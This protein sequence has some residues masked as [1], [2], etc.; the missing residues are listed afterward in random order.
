[1]KKSIFKHIILFVFFFLGSSNTMLAQYC[2]CPTC[3][4]NAC[5]PTS[6]IGCLFACFSCQG[7]QGA[8]TF[9]ESTTENCVGT[10]CET[11]LPV[12]LI[13]FSGKVNRQKTGVVLNWS[14]AS[15]LNN[16]GFEILRIDK[17]LVEWESLGFVEGKGTTNLENRYEFTDEKAN[18]GRNYYRLKQIDF[19]GV[20]EFSKMLSVDFQKPGDMVSIFPTLVKS[21]LFF[22]FLEIPNDHPHIQIFDLTGRKIWEERVERMVINLDELPN[23]QYIIMVAY[24]YKE[25]TGRFVK[26]GE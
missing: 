3:P 9:I 22:E 19:D 24:N 23:G 20:S 7:N 10:I 21:E 25:W 17:D 15:E 14:T 5:V 6:F 13:S 12:E 2:C 4:G 1:M 11:A 8:V 16:K 26:V 18:L